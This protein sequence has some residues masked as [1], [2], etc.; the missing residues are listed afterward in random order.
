A[1]RAIDKGADAGPTVCSCF[2]VG[3]N[4]ICNAIKKQNLSTVQQLGQTLKCGTN[5]GSCIPELKSILLEMN[6]EVE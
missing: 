1:G 2:G 5:C 6:V 3:R 4:T